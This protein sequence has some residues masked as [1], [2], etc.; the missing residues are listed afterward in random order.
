M[1]WE[2]SDCFIYMHD[3]VKRMNLIKMCLITLHTRR[4]QGSFST[5]KQEM[6]KLAETEFS[7]LEIQGAPAWVVKGVLQR[8]GRAPALSS[9]L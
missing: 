4:C 2:P 6:T 7:Q 3:V 5:E 1:G 9:A 8:E